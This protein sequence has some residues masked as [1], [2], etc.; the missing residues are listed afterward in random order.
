MVK[1]LSNSAADYGQGRAVPIRARSHVSR[2]S[3]IQ[4]ALAL[5]RTKGF[6]ETTVTD[7][8]KAA[9]VSKALFYVYFARKEDVLLHLELFVVDDAKRAAEKVMSRA[10]EL[11]DLIEA[12]VAVLERTMRRYPADLIFETLIESYRAEGRMLAEGASDHELAFLFLEPFEQAHRD[13]KLRDDLDVIT[14]ARV[15]QQ[16]V[17]DGIRE[18]AA[19]GRLDKP[20]AGALAPVVSTLISR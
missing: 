17:A 2:D 3:I 12:V 7:I 5:W 8:C 18:W 4:G 11:T 16:L 10:Y 19:A 13:G 9:G 14:A 20:L 6:A 15:A 1:A